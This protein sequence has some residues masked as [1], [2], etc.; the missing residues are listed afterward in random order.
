MLCGSP[1]DPNVAAA[2]NAM[3]TGHGWFSNLDNCAFDSSGGLWVGTDQSS[4]WKKASGTADGI[5]A[6]E[7]EGALRATGKTVVPS[8]ADARDGLVGV[9]IRPVRIQFTKLREQKK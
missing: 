6:V 8:A 1:K 3:T 2:W 4:R 9:I 7:T 5:W